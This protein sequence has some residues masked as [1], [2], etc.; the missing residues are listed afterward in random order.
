MERS[1][2][3]P[4]SASVMFHLTHA[5]KHPTNLKLGSWNVNFHSTYFPNFSIRNTSVHLSA[6]IVIPDCPTMLQP[7]STLSLVDVVGMR[8]Q[9]RYRLLGHGPL[10]TRPECW[11]LRMTSEGSL[12]DR[13]FQHSG[14]VWS[15]LWLG[16]STVIR[17]REGAVV[18]V[19]NH[20]W[21][22]LREKVLQWNL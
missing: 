12:V 1:Q 8:Q 17:D 13:R 10:H 7:W 3:G 4:D 6:I 22:L 20:H 16:I 19:R 5:H 9:P 18:C 15:G 14:L 2:F 11:N 21:Q